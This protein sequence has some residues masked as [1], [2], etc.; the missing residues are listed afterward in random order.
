M[1]TLIAKSSFDGKYNFTLDDRMV[2]LI[3]RPFTDEYRELADEIDAFM[4]KSMD[5]GL[6]NEEQQFNTIAEL[7][8]YAMQDSNLDCLRRS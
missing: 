2:C 3:D 1:V 4:R 8:E 5:S 7:I 6:D